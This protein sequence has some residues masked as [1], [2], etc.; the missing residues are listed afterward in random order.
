MIFQCVLFPSTLWLSQI[1]LENNFIINLLSCP[2]I[3][4]KLFVYDLYRSCK[5]LLA[6]Q[7][8]VVNHDICTVSSLLLLLEEDKVLW[9]HKIMAHVLFYYY[10]RHRRCRHWWSRLNICCL[11]TRRVSCLVSL[12]N[13]LPLVKTIKTSKKSSKLNSTALFKLMNIKKNYKR[14]N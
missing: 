5:L 8:I 6:M 1:F 10:L 3:Q 4:K 11:Y 12:S 9:S 14:K 2:I 13:F 7:T